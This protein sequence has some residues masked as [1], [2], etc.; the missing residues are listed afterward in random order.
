[1]RT[2]LVLTAMLAAMVGG[3]LALAGCQTRVVT[4]PAGTPTNTVTSSGT[5]EAQAVPDVAMMTF[6]ATASGPDAQQVLDDVSQAAE[7]ITDALKDAG[8]ADEDIQTRN[9]SLYPT[10]SDQSGTLEIVGYQANIS[11]SA[12][13]RE[14]GTLGEVITAANDAGAD[15]ISGPTFTLSEDSEYR[16]EAIEQAV[17]DAREVAEAMAEAGGKSVGEVLSMS[18]ADVS[19]PSPI[20]RGDVALEAPEAAVPIEPGELDVTAQVTV[21]FELK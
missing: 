18:S 17:E 1:M 19:V 21:V 5:G 12:E 7:Q 15:S 4:A 13:V 20:F 14:L 8:V 10:T 6:G 2:R 16:A 9:V 3:S 11:V